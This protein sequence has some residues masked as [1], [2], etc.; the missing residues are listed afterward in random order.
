MDAETRTI[1]E[2]C[3]KG[4]YEGT[5][6]FP[7]I[8]GALLG[9]GFE[10]YH[11]DYR[12]STSTYYLADRDSVV[13]DN[14]KTAGA[15]ARAF[16]ASGVEA[17]VREAQAKVPGY[18]YRGFCEKVKGSG[19]AG[20]IVSFPGRRVIYYGRTAETHVEHFPQT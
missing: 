11:V 2:N 7:D 12:A 1:A 18:T 3:L 9:A 19:C 13:L 5:I 10:G 8:I 4:S 14:P 15:I 20:Y 16:D 6:A 17:S